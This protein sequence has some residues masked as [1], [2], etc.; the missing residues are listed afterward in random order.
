MNYQNRGGH[1]NGLDRRSFLAGGLVAAGALPEAAKLGFGKGPADAAGVIPAIAEKSN[2]RQILCGPMIPL[3][4]QY[5]RD[6]TLDLGAYKEY[7]QY[8]LDH[9]IRTGQGCLLVAGA[10]GDFPM[11][12]VAERITLAHTAVEVV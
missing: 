7:I 6:L 8:L 5:N 1:G 2:C 9:G 3:V 10:G 12:T 11:L 4:T